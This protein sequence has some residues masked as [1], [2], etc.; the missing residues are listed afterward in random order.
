[1]QLLHLEWQKVF[2][3]LNGEKIEFGEHDERVVIAQSILDRCGYDSKYYLLVLVDADGHKEMVP[4]P[5]NGK[6]WLRDGITFFA[7]VEADDVEKFSN[8]CP[9][10][11][12]G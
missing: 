3:T 4:V 7:R 8:H 6:L 11:K 9:A 1:M 12:I 5:R 2:Y 10:R